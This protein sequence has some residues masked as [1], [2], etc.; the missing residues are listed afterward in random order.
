[1]MTATIQPTTSV[2]PSQF[3]QWAMHINSALEKSGSEREFPSRKK[4][5]GG[6][7]LKSKHIGKW[8]AKGKVGLGDDHPGKSGKTT[9]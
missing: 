8:Q 9:K 4:G 6:G 7:T 5:R 3:A 1:M 2:W